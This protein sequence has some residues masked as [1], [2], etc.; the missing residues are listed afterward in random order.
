MQEELA[1]L[2]TALSEPDF[3]AIILGSLPKSYNQFISAVIATASI[4]KRDL[5]PEDLMQT[6][7]HEYNRQL[8]RSGVLKE[9]G[10]DAAFFAGDTN[11]RG[12]RVGK[13]MNK[14]VECFNCHKKGHKKLDCWAKGG[15]KEGQGPKSKER[16]LKGGELKKGDQAVANIAEDEGGVWMA[17]ANNSDNEMADD[18]FNDFEISDDDLPIFEESEDSKISDLTTQLK[19][20]LKIPDSPQYIRYPEDNTKDILDRRNF[21][22]SSDDEQGAVAM[23]VSSESDSKINIDPYWSKVKIDKLQGLG[24]PMEAIVS[25]DF[26]PDLGNTSESEGSQDSVILVHTPPNSFC[27][28]DSEQGSLENPMISSDEEMMDLTIDEGEEGHTTFNA[29]MLVNV[30]GSVEGIQTELY[31]S[32]ASRHMLPYRDHFENYVPIAPKSVTAA[33]KHY[34]QAIG[35]GDLWIRIPNGTGVTTVLLKDVLHC[36]DMGLTLVSVRKITAASY[37]VIF[38]G[39]TCRIYDS[40][41][42]IIGQINARNGLYHVD[43]EATVNIAMAGEAREILTLEELHKQMG[44]IAP[45]TIKKMVSDKTIKG[46][47]VDLTTPIQ[48]CASCEYGKATRKPIKKFQETP[49]APKFGDKMHSDV[50]GP[51]PVQTLGHKEYYVSFTDDHTRWTHLKLLASKIEVFKA[52]RNYETWAKLHFSISAFKVL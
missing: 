17:I 9:K 6:I 14:D 21:T 37:K 25:D 19:Q 8:T 39:M 52:Y 31:D 24:N 38:R 28:T 1:S 48:H 51:S 47:E 49:R 5:D 23:Q 44:H 34:F 35:K 2:G 45:A 15:G 12:G 33:D 36:P 46:V 43:H 3:S 32:G 18:E 10:L 16:K 7:I 11:S 50:W 13:R 41:E 4:L 40:R 20:I 22:D 42:K 26:K 30:E 29:A 27:S